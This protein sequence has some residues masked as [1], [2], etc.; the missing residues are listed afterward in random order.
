M[1]QLKQSISVKNMPSLS[2]YS[3]NSQQSSR[4]FWFKLIFLSYIKELQK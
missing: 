4:K 2:L 3:K 1:D